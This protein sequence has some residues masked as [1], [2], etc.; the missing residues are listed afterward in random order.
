MHRLVTL[1]F[2]HYNEKA[3]WALDHCGIDY[4]RRYMPGFSQLAVMAATRGRGGAADAVSSRYSTPLLV[5]R[6]GKILSDSTEIAQWASD[7]AGGKLFPTPET[8]EVVDALGRELGPHTRLVAYFHV[9]GN[10]RAVRAL[11]ENNVSRR[12]ALA[13]RALAPVGTRLIRRGLGVTRERS[14]RSLAKVRA[15]VKQIGERLERGPYLVG[16]RFT[17][18][19]LTFAALMA[20]VLLVSRSEGYGATFPSRDEMG[21]EVRALVDEMRATK[22]G[23]FALEMFRRHR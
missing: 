3:R 7:Q 12:Q 23:Q 21:S 9:L 4:E 15:Q 18:A 17:A 10:E 14:E 20:P 1:A 22:A 19:D 2:S 6:D 13:F 5:T 11:A 16:D 8:L